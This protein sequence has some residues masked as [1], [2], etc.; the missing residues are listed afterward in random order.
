MSDMSVRMDVR[1]PSD[2]TSIID[3]HGDV[4]AACEDAL[5]QAYTA[6]SGPRT[7][8]IILNLSD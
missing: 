2:A 5:M 4:N 6:A 1:R 8:A 3:I 7:R